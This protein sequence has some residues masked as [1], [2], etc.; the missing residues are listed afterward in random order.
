MKGI[1]M[2]A[3]MKVLIAYD[4]SSSAQA[5][6]AELPRA[7]GLPPE[8]EAVVISTANVVLSPAPDY[9]L[10]TSV[11]DRLS[12][13]LRAR[14]QAHYDIV[15]KERE[16]A[17]FAVNGALR[18]GLQAA[19]Q[20][21]SE[22]PTWDVRAEA[23]ADSPASAVIK[24]ADDWGA[25]LIVV[26]TDGRSALG[27]LILGSVSKKIVN[28]AA[29]S[30]RVARSQPPEGDSMARIIV[31]LDGSTFAEKAARAVAER[32]WPASS[33]ARLV[34]AT[35]PFG[36][37]GNAPDEQHRR[38]AEMQRTVET[39]LREAGLNVSSAIKEGEAMNVLIAEAES[40]GAD[41][42]FVGSR[43][44]DSAFKRF[45]LGSVS[46]S[47]VANASCTVEVVR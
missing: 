28:E 45:F 7:A 42:I 26:G 9:L 44:L 23:F 35:K 3:R 24:K 34:T 25:D 22:F 33:E 30:V 10:A 13:L 6:L 17:L 36:L 12:T 2:S 20:I 11:N 8:V 4:G 29:C 37:Y 14:V 27:R 41:S 40:W 38:A 39:M 1:M 31:G 18:L 32:S 5:A 16:R 46:S 19:E 47:V 43:G 21:K 15:M